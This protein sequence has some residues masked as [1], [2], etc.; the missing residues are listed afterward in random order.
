MGIH[1]GGQSRR[2]P[3]YTP[4][5]K[6]FAPIPMTD[7]SILPLV[8][9]DVQLNL[10]LNYPWRTG[11]VLL[12][13]GD[14]TIDF[15]PEAVPENRGEICGFTKNAAFDQGSRHGVYKVDTQNEK[16]LDYYQKATVP[17]LLEHASFGGNR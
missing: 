9:L 11:E 17:F 12:S 2:L 5:G 3:F 14:V 4:E 8:I 10:F 7:S 13:S 16:V 1:T 15:S 6:F